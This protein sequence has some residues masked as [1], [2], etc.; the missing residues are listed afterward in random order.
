[1]VVIRH[2]KRV[3]NVTNVTNVLKEKFL[4]N[5]CCNA[6]LV[7]I[8]HSLL[9]NDT[10]AT[11]AAGVMPCKFCKRHIDYFLADAKS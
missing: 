7:E 3:Y 4:S 8:K 10:H 6:H 1:M 9:T 5:T 2:L 11:C